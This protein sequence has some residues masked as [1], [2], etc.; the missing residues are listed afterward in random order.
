MNRTDN[1]W[2]RFLLSIC[3]LILFVVT[4]LNAQ[5]IQGKNRIDSLVQVAKRLDGTQKVDILNGIAFEWFGLDDNKADQYASQALKLSEEL[6]YDKGKSESLIYRGLYYRFNGDNQQ[7]LSF[8]RRGITL[9]QKSGNKQMEGYGLIQLATVLGSVGNQDSSFLLFRQSYKILKDSL[10]P[11]QLS[12]LYKNWGLAYGRKL[13]HELA[14]DYL[15]RSLEIRKLLGEPVM[16]VDIYLS[17]S[18]QFTLESKVA[19]ASQYITMADS[20]SKN[21]N[22]SDRMTNDI[23]FHRALILMKQSRYEESFIVLNELKQYYAQYKSKQDYVKLLS[24]IGYALVDL[25]NYEFGLSNYYEALQLAESGNLMQE[26]SR[27]Y[28]QLSHVHNLLKQYRDAK[29]FARKSLR[30]AEAND[31]LVEEATAYNL[32]GLVLVEEGK[33][34]SALTV[35][36][37]ALELREKI[38]DKVRIASTMGNIGDVLAR[39][40]KYDLAIDYWKHAKI[41]MANQQNTEGE[42]WTNSAL[43]QIYLQINQFAKAKEYLDRAEEQAIQM[44]S[45][46]ILQDI[47]QSKAKYY[48]QLNNLPESLRFYKLYS[49]L[50]DS[51]YSASL[52]DRLVNLHNQFN[53]LQKNQQIELLNRDKTLREQEIEVGKSR[54]NQQRVI[55]F[56]GIAVLLLAFAASYAFYNNYR[57]ASRLNRNIQEKNEEIQAQAE[58][59]H[60]SNQMILQIN[61]SLEQLVESRTA[62][63]KQAYKELDTFFY[64][65]SHD[66]RRPLTTFMGLAEVAK[67]AV[68]DEQALHLFEKVNETARS[69]DKMLVKLQ[70]VS[71]VGATNLIH[72]EIFFSDIF[73]LASEALQ[74]EIKQKNIRLSTEIHVKGKFYSYPALLK[75]ITENLLENAVTFSESGSEVL[76]KAYSEPGKICLEVKDNGIGIDPEYQD[77]IFDMYFRA[78]ERSKGNGLGLYIVKRMVE[79]LRGEIKMISKPGAGTTVIISFDSDIEHS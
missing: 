25:G 35:Y 42:A 5:K 79:K 40:K 51:V 49:N 45:A 30:I 36:R 50:R 13:E 77:K 9:A 74:E 71:D 43:G 64:R 67:I 12:S 44:K 23:K 65:S 18:E 21:I 34:D 27:L 29:E 19:E 16:L 76:L 78:H 15:S 31:F 7:A 41:L 4:T 58:E 53:V 48:E 70:S 8:L 10:Y 55:I 17:L 6:G 47:Y 66:F 2:Y 46:P 20:L 72:K 26:K 60:S 28:W 37:K 32:M 1:N 11:L 24:S 75:I 52:S 14:R 38:D 63:L 56:S 57:N 39:Q 54:I 61:Q 33:L 69:L 68:K 22:A 73:E 59:L 3:L 62:E